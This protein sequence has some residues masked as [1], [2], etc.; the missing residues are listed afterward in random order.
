[1]ISLFDEKIMCV[2]CLYTHLSRL[3][4]D[5]ELKNCF[6]KEFQGLLH[7]K[8]YICSVSTKFNGE[9][10]L[11]DALNETNFCCRKGLSV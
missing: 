2:Q 7:V 5:I 10:E 1:M 11:L 9:T 4:Q 8:D 6:S 3:A